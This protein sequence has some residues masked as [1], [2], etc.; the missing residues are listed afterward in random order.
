M[1][2]EGWWVARTNRLP[3]LVPAV[4]CWIFA[5]TALIWPRLGGLLIILIGGTF[6]AW[7]CS[8]QCKKGN[9]HPPAGLDVILT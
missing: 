8:N 3:Y 2:Y 6:T 1:Y 5:L 4:V 7:R 9:T